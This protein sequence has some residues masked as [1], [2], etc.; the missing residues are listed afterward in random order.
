M[1]NRDNGILTTLNVDAAPA[2]VLCNSLPFIHVNM[3]PMI[4]MSAL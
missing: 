4:D 3:R 2:E 1:E